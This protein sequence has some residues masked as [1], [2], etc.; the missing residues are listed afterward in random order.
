MR[1]GQGASTHPP[2]LSTWAIHTHLC[3]LPQ[4]SENSGYPWGLG[5]VGAWL[6]EGPGC[7]PGVE[8]SAGAGDQV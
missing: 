2:L 5:A 1:V 3:L 6:G 8:A 7:W 4:L